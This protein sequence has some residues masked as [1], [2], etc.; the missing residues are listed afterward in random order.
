MLQV[1]KHTI[2]ECTYTTH[3]GDIQSDNSDKSGIICT[4]MIDNWVNHGQ[5]QG[6]YI[7]VSGYRNIF[8]I[9]AIIIF[10]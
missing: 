2:Q 3:Q 6:I 9:S 1:S 10:C 7:E 8:I 4:K 5:K